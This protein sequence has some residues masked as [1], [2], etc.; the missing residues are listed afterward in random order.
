[1]SP[2]PAR[3]ITTRPPPRLGLAAWLQQVR[4]R[5]D[6]RPWL[7]LG[8][9]PTFARLDSGHRER[10]HLFGLNHVVR[11]V[12]VAIAHA[13]DIDVVRACRGAL[14]A[15]CEWLLLPRVPHVAS[16]P[17]QRLLEQWFDE[18]PELGELERRGRL[19]WYNCSTAPGGP[20]PGSPVVDVRYFSSE[21]A[22]AIL[23]AMGVR[24]IR[25]L[26]IDGG[27]SYAPGFGASDG[28]TRLQNGQPLFDRQ[29]ERIAAVV[30]RHGIDYAPLVPP[31]RIRIVAGEDLAI[32]A[33][34][35]AH[36]IRRH[37]SLPVEVARSAS[38]AEAPQGALLLDAAAL[39]TGDVAGAHATGG[40]AGARLTRFSAPVPWRDVG[41]AGAEP[42]LDA[43][44]EAVTVGAV[45]PQAVRS[46]VRAGHVDAQL[47]RLPPP[48]PPLA[49][50]ELALASHR[51]SVLR[52]ELA[53]LRL[54]R[55]WQLGR[56]LVSPAQ[57]AG[58][59]L[60]GGRR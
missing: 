38:A 28:T 52:R 46:A 22:F 60:R 45:R 11:A 25:S 20:L 6:D 51:A 55:S 33:E 35:L 44:A 9:G 32:A 7:V 21:A 15:N 31:V 4:G 26:G 42:W 58:R 16:A 18:L 2:V 57:A 23:A 50:D 53:N 13:I 37:T 14:L 47:L 59:L 48:P 30:A 8:K 36:S 56:L 54:S 41:A 5:Y 17:G 39:A 27:R 24:T 34:V 43:F 10:H 40:D 19:V 3:P 49:A 12:P 1:M 29:F